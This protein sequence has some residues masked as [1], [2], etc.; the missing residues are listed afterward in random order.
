MKNKREPYTECNHTEFIKL[1]DEIDETITSYHRG[2]ITKEQ[3]IQEYSSTKM[4]AL[5]NSHIGYDDFRV[6]SMLCRFGC[7]TCEVKTNE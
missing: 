2:G 6:I 7:E 3:A 5:L 1:I 4:Q